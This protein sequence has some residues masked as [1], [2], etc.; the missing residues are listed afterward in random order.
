[1]TPN[2]KPS[3]TFKVP[4]AVIGQVICDNY[5]TGNMI[6]HLPGTIFYWD[7]GES[8]RPEQVSASRINEDVH[9][10]PARISIDPAKG[11][12][13]LIANNGVKIIEKTTATTRF[14]YDGLTYVLHH[15]TRSTET[16]PLRTAII[17]IPNYM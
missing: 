15:C 5:F 14:S 3:T 7:P 4:F 9:I 11:R 17:E 13:E 8:A 10:Y 12:L 1:M 16:L 2:K 6:N